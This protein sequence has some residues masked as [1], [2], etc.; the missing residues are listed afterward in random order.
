MRG[1]A[2]ALRRALA[3]RQRRG[4]C[5]GGLG[6]LARGGSG[7]AFHDADFVFGEAVEFV[8]EAVNPGIGGLDFAVE[9]GLLLRRGS[10]TS[11]YR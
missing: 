2:L 4:G 10:V 7:R 11:C 3:L 6:R 8:N 1:V 5:G 9:A